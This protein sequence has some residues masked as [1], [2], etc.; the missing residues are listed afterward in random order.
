M[1]CLSA[2]SILLQTHSDTFTGH[3]HSVLRRG[4]D[5]ENCNVWNR[6]QFLK[7]VLALAQLKRNKNGNKRV[8]F[9]LKTHSDEIVFSP[10]C[11]AIF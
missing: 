1:R 6:S 10:V 8:R 2:E 4:A 3:T 5:T 9:H 11:V 7:D